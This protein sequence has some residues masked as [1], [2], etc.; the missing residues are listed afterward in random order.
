[1]WG[2]C[3]DTIV[4]ITDRIARERGYILERIATTREKGGELKF[5]E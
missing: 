3:G 1:L 2:F 5:G 4:I